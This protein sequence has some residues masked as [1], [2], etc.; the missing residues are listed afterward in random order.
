MR[1]IPQKN[2][3]NNTAASSPTKDFPSVLL[4]LEDLAQPTLKKALALDPDPAVGSRGWWES[5]R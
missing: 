5:L 4:G 1:K 2:L 3:T